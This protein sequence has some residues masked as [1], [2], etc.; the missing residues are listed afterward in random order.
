MFFVV[1]GIHGAITPILFNNLFTLGYDPINACMGL[2][3]WA[4]AGAGLGYGLKVRNKEKKSMG[5]SNTVTALCGITEPSIYSMLLPH[6]K[7]FGAV[8]AGGGISG[9]ILAALGGKMY[10]WVGDGIFRIPGMINPAGLDVSFYG[11]IICAAVSFVIS[12]IV[13]FLLTD[14]NWDNDEIMNQEV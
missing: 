3:V 4:V 7:L 1:L 12:A 10:S 8:I 6:A 11:F 14:K 2:S 9:M 13:A 5:L